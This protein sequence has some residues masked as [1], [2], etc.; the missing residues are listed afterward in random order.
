MTHDG[1]VNKHSEIR[2][3]RTD[4]T[5]VEGESEAHRAYR[6]IEQ[7]IVSLELPPGSRVSAQSLSSSL[8]IGRTPVREA[9]QR[10]ALEGT[11]RVLPRSGAVVLSIDV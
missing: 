2:L 10:L 6:L 5:A 1:V 4:L 9:L 7:L 11:I 8:E 3:T